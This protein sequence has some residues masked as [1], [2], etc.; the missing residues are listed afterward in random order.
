MVGREA[1]LI[2]L[3][4]RNSIGPADAAVQDLLTIMRSEDQAALDDFVVNRL[5]QTIDPLT[6]QIAAIVDLQLEEAEQSAT[7]AQEL[8]DLGVIEVVVL[9]T[10]CRS[11]AGD[12]VRHKIE[13]QHHPADRASSRRQ[14]KRFI[15]GDFLVSMPTLPLR[16]FTHI[17]HMLNATRASLAYSRSRSAGRTTDWP[18]NSD[19]QALRNMADTVETEAGAAVDQVGLRTTSAVADQARAMADGAKRM[20]D[21]ACHGRRGSP[22][23][24]VQRPDSRRGRRGADGI[25][26]GNY[27]AGL[28]FQRSHPRSGECRRPDV[29]HHFPFVG[30]KSP[31]SA[32]S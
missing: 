27:G 12:P 6:A 11:A 32:R 14:L 17:S 21:N 3:P 29:E 20:S 9:L 13:Q 18:L 16:E 10:S 22:R 30:P 5:Y 26:S 15:Q 2:R 23:C 8:F 24:P 28:S 1:E 4:P 7:D 19:R 31:R 25:D